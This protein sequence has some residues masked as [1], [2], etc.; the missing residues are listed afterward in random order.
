MSMKRTQRFG[1]WVA[2][3]SCL[4]VLGLHVL[5]RAEEP[6]RMI[7]HLPVTDE[8]MKA[9]QRIDKQLDKILEVQGAILQRYDELMEELQ[10]VKVRASQ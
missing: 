7:R 10:V 6:S 4:A 2:A 5:V 3:A 1:R 8:E 9:K